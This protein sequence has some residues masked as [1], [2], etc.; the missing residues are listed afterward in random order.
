MATITAIEPLKKDPRRVSIYLDGQFAFDLAGILAAWLKPGQDLDQNKIRS[1]RTQDLRE[2]AYEQSL[3]FLSYRARS[4]AEIR[5]YLRKHKFAED[6]VGQTLQRLRANRLADDEKFAQTWV[7]NRTTFRPRSRRVLAWELQQK[8]VAPEK[9]GPALAGLDEE[10]LAYEAGLKKA[11][12]LVD[13]EWDDFRAKLTGFLARRG[14]P[15]PVIAAV[16]SRLWDQRHAG[17]HS[18]RN[19]EDMR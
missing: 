4:E 14:F 12:H 11:P 3:D 18:D 19:D 10:K 13:V 17:H 15:Y 1:L 6:V 5:K 7:E 8:G 16:V 2:R 9:V